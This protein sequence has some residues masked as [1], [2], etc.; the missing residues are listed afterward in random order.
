MAGSQS[1]GGNEEK[2]T[3]LMLQHVRDAVELQ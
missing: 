1:S 2:Q 3:L